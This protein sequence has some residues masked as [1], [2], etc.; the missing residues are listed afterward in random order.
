MMAV[1][2]DLLP[3]LR[4]LLDPLARRRVARERSLS[5]G[6]FYRPVRGRR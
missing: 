5:N 1:S 4:A 2:L 6:R 3:R